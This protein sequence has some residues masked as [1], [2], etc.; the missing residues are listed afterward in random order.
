MPFPLHRIVVMV[1]QANRNKNFINGK[2]KYIYMILLR[3][4]EHKLKLTLVSTEGRI[5]KKNSS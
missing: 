2:A 4:L 5:F 1:E 3:F